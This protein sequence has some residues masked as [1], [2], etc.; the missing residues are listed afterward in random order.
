MLGCERSV[1]TSLQAC[2]EARSYSVVMAQEDAGVIASTSF[3]EA[4]LLE[5]CTT[6]KAVS[7]DPNTA[8]K[9]SCR[10]N[11]AVEAAA[12]SHN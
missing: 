11:L 3:E 2:T 10:T 8:I 1:S 6:S 12:T 7:S 4:K 9:F 5:N